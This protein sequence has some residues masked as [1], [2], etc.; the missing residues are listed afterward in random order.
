MAA[1][2]NVFAPTGLS[3]TRNFISGANTYQQNLSAIKVGYT[4]AIAMGDLVK[5]GTGAQQGYVNLSLTTD[6]V[7]LG[8]FGGILAYYDQTLQTTFHGLNGAYQTTLNPAADIPCVVV[9]DPFAAFAVQV[10]APSNAFTQS[11]IGQN[12]NFLTGTNGVANTAGRS[13]LALDYTTLGTSNTLPFRIIGPWGYVG[14][15][16]D[17]TNNNPWVEVRLNTSAALQA[18]GI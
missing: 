12:I 3:F 7:H 6:T 16:Q 11:W 2:S 18:T 10:S 15:P 14:G 1:T 8:V 13:T 17:P 9:M 4:T 5:I